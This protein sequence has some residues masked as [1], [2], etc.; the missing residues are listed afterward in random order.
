M[1]G[2]KNIEEREKGRGGDREKRVSSERRGEQ[3]GGREGKRETCVEGIR[4][5]QHWEH[6]AIVNKFPFWISVSQKGCPVLSLWD[7]QPPSY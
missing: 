7:L 2:K 1:R 5:G 6:L 3:E 4:V